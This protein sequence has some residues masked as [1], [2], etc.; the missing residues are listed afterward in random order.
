MVNTTTHVVKE[1]SLFQGNCDFEFLISLRQFKCYRTSKGEH[2]AVI[3]MSGYYDIN[4]H[5]IQV[6]D[7]NNKKKLETLELVPLRIDK[8][9][10]LYEI[11]V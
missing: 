4:L 5:R 2:I 7:K 1:L 3:Q 10:K 8:K 11:L 9:Y 6:I